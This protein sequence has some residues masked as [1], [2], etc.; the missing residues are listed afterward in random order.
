MLA[1]LTIMAAGAPSAAAEVVQVPATTWDC[2][3]RSDATTSACSSSTLT[4]GSTATTK[5]RVLAR[6]PVAEHVPRGAVITGARLKL[7]VTARSSSRSIAIGAHDVTRDW[8]STATWSSAGGQAWTSPGGDFAST[9]VASA[10]GVGSALGALSMS[11]PVELVRRWHDPH[12]RNQ[13]LLLKQSTEGSTSQVVSLDSGDA[14][15]NKPTVEVTY[16][17]A[18]AVRAL[19]MVFRGAAT[20][21]AAPVLWGA[22]QDGTEPGPI[23]T[24]PATCDGPALS[25]DG[26]QVA[27]KSGYGTLAVVP[28]DGSTAKTASWRSRESRSVRPSS[29]RRAT[30]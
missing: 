17:P 27:C 15:A 11:L 4:L 18:N 28:T 10:T 30:R 19:G 26:M 1:V 20:P 24:A 29:R 6:F 25:A 22:A 3:L 2:T 23:T 9:T 14:Y 13:G 8:T 5:R 7:N 12:V 21:G 16:T